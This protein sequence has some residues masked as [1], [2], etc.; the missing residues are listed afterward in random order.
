MQATSV[1]SDKTAASAD[2]ATGA[3]AAVAAVIRRIPRRWLPVVVVTLV[4]AVAALPLA[5]T[6][7][8]G[9]RPDPPRCRRVP[10]W[11]TSSACGS[12]LSQLS[13]TVA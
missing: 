5:P 3:T 9:R 8:P 1:K 2:T 11:R 4:L 6:P 12:P 13:V 7:W 10:R